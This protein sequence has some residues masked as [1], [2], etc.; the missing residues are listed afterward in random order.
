[1]ESQGAFSEALA[2]AAWEEKP[3][4]PAEKSPRLRDLNYIQV[5][6]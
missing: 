6:I 1:M 2:C 4:A 5:N 3:N